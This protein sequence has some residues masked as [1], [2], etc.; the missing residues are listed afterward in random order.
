MP[1]CGTCKGNLKT[2]PR[3]VKKAI[4]T[5]WSDFTQPYGLYMVHIFFFFHMQ[6]FPPEWLLAGTAVQVQK[7]PNTKAESAWIWCLQIDTDLLQ[8]RGYLLWVLQASLCFGIDR[9]SGDVWRG[10]RRLVNLLCSS[11]TSYVPYFIK[12]RKRNLNAIYFGS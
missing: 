7:T 2:H 8:E 4:C 3:T 12:D 5:W 10:N 1:F 9:R 6:L 11:H